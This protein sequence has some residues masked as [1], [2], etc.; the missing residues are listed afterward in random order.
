MCIHSRQGEVSDIPDIPKTA[1]VVPVKLEAVQQFEHLIE[2]DKIETCELVHPVESGQIDMDAVKKFDV[3]MDKSVVLSDSLT[4]AEKNKQP[5][6]ET[7]DF[8]RVYKQDGHLLS[9]IEY[10]INGN[11]YRTDANGNLIS[12]DA[13]PQYTQEGTRNLKEQRESGGTDRLEQDDGGHIVARVMGGT[14]GTENLVPMRRTINRGD[15]KKMENEIVQHLKAGEDVKLHVDV[16]YP[17]NGKRPASMRATYVI[18]GKQIEIAF[19]N[20]ENSTKLL[21]EV[22]SKLSTKQYQA[23]KEELQQM[24]KDGRV[25]AIT[26]VKTESNGEE[27]KI[28]IG[29]LDETTGIKNYR[30]YLT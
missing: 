13:R 19:D 30:V 20:Q 27:N 4:A 10:T 12:C 7:D 6:V 24:H 1:D 5:K 21:D 17:E 3:L 8:G 15:Y 29:I 25:N 22:Q 9:N 11:T 23:L 28:T 26:S 14:Q 16:L 18:D 2:D